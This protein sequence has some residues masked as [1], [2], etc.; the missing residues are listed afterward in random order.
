MRKRVGDALRQHVSRIAPEILGMRFAVH[1][2]G[3]IEAFHR[4]GLRPI[5]QAQQHVRQGQRHVTGVFGV[6][7][8]RPGDEFRRFEA[9][10]Q[11]AR[12]AHLRE[13]IPIEELGAG[14]RKK[15]RVCRG[16]DIRD[17]FQDRHILRVAPEFIVAHQ[18]AIGIPA[19][20]AVLLFV[21][22]LEHHALI[23]FGGL[24]H[25]AQQLFLSQV[26][27]PEFQHGAGFRIHYKIIQPAPCSF[28]LLQLPVVENLIELIAD[29][30]IDLG[31]VGFD[32]CHRV[33]R[34]LHALI[35]HLADEFADQSAGIR[36]LLRI[37]GHAAFQHDLVE[38]GQS[39]GGAAV[40]WCIGFGFLVR[41]AELLWWR[42][43][44]LPRRL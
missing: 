20:R 13:A 3:E 33:R 19:E 43:P 5:R 11:I 28:Q 39:R 1:V 24:L 36:L 34:N 4:D 8:R 44:W 14:H 32:R 12:R 29:P 10:G 23:E 17:L 40:S 41:H 30:L 15:W 22:A 27:Q 7:E 31:D 16:G 26:E 37:F 38:Q 42:R 6:A 21:D 25:V 2:F 9:F 35:E 18:A